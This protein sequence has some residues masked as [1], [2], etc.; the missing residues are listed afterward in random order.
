M[1]GDDAMGALAAEGRATLEVIRK[2]EDFYVEYTASSLNRDQPGKESR[3]V[4]AEISGFIGL[5]TQ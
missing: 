5:L 4:L 2:I 1:S 3:I